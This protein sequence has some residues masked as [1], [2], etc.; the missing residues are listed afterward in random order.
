MQWR[1]SKRRRPRPEG[2]AV[3]V[4]TLPGDVVMPE[5]THSV[6]AAPAPERTAQ[7]ALLEFQPPAD[8]CAA[9]ARCE[10]VRLEG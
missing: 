9:D 3:I 2:G 7:G 6:F 5:G 1:C 4:L 8:T 10:Q